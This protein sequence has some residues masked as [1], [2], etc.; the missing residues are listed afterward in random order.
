M[1]ELALFRCGRQLLEIISSFFS[2][3]EFWVF[4]LQSLIS[5]TVY[6][7]LKQ[8]NEAEDGC[9]RYRHVAELRSFEMVY[10]ITIMYQRNLFLTAVFGS[11]FR[12]NL[13]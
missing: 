11:G 4:F 12:S 13:Q 9:Y 10:D 2:A 1:K 6:A 8:R 7:S 3:L 5:Q